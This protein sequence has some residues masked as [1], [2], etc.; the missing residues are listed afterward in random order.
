MSSVSSRILLPVSVAAAYRVVTDLNT[1]IRLS[2]FFTLKHIEPQAD[3]E[4]QKGDRYRL[5]IEYYGNKMIE[6][7]DVEI[8]RLEMDRLISYTLG[9]SS[10][11]NIRFELEPVGEGVQLAQTFNLDAENEDIIKGTQDELHMWLS[12]IG[13]YLKLSK[14]NSPLRRA[15]KWFMDRI[16]LRLTIS[17]RTIAMIMVKI[18]IFELVLLL[19]LVLIWNVWIRR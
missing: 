3:R 11:R 6:T 18:S 9:N 5:T 1:I 13:N 16:W 12:H 4:V 15:Q 7:H 2:P 17:E 10:V 14:G 19:I 8:D